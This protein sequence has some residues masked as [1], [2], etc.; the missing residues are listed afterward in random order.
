MVS[1]C[2]KN[3]RSFAVKRRRGGMGAEGRGMVKSRD[4][5][6]CFRAF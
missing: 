5:F 2:I 1:M 4:G 3:T 6:S